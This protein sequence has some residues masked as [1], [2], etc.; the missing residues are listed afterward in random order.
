MATGTISITAVNDAPVM[1]LN[2]GWGGND[3][4]AAFTEQTPV[5][6]AP[7][8]TLSDADSANLSSLTVT[9]TA[10]PDGYTVES[11][12]LNST[13]AAA[14]SGLTV[15]YTA[16]TGVLSI[17]GSASRATYET[18]LQGI[19]YNNTSDMPTTSNRS[20]T[21]VANDG[22]AASISRTVTVTVAAVNDAPVIDLNAGGVG[23]DVTTA[24]T[25]QTPV[26]I[27]PVATLTDVDSA[28][29][30]SLIVTLAARPDGNAVESLSL[31]AAATSA[32]SGLT[33]SYNSSTGVLSITGSASKRHMKPFCGASN[34][35]I[36]VI[37]QRL[38]IVR[39]A[40][41]PMMYGER[42]TDCYVD[43]C[44]CE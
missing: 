42:H 27:A 1:D 11:L 39:L 36:R 10:R 23:N 12:S 40:W 18:I 29:L 22:A 17:T 38:R 24:F 31:N 21:V 30:T 26:L 6:I 20:I 35:T 15:T 16:S 8:A 44:G 7:I 41:L 4:T 43:S 37:R 9:L 5:L 3:A 34:T 19:Q 25:E 32:A 33:V 28:N 2:A 14:A 13:A